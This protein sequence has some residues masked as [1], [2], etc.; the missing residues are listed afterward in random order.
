[1]V[2]IKVKPSQIYQHPTT[3]KTIDPQAYQSFHQNEIILFTLGSLLL[4]IAINLMAL[5]SEGPW[6]ANARISSKKDSFDGF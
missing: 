2:Y 5:E 3:N 1:M 6:R 4:H